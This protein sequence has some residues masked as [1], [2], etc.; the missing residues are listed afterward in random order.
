MDLR[1]EADQA[2]A[3]DRPSH[4]HVKLATGGLRGARPA[5]AYLG[6]QPRTRKLNP[7]RRLSQGRHMLAE[8]IGV[9]LLPFALYPRRYDDEGPPE[10]SAA[11][12]RYKGRRDVLHAA[13]AGCFSNSARCSLD[14]SL[15]GRR[16]S[17]VI[18]DTWRAIT[19]SGGV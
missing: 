7:R 13:S 8:L 17:A 3:I 19:F 6:E 9:A 11:Q 1:W 18:C 12:A 16:R 5:T 10:E 2:E 4:H 15:P 14:W